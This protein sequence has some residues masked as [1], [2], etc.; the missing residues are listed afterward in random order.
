MTRPKPD[1]TENEKGIVATELAV[2]FPILLF[3]MLLLAQIV[4]WSHAKNVARTAADVAAE[5]ASLITEQGSEEDA[6]TDAANALLGAAGGLDNPSIV[7][8][9]AAQT[10]TVTIRG[11]SLSVVGSWGI[12]ES[13]TIPL[14]RIPDR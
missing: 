3:L 4:F 2:L 14:E 8:V 11:G 5:A 9:V 12:E 10:V 6:A 1:N 13:V 7:V